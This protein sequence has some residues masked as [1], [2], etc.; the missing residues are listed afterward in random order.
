V[1]RTLTKVSI[2]MMRPNMKGKRGARMARTTK[3]PKK[4]D[5]GRLLQQREKGESGRRF[6]D[7]LV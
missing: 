1:A 5:H 6:G 7:G 4:R 3:N 2:P